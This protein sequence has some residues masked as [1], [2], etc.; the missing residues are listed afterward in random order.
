MSKKIYIENGQTTFDIAIQQFGGV[1]G[2]FSLIRDN[3]DLSSVNDNVFAGHQVNIAD[4]VISASVR[5]Y[6]PNNKVVP[7]S[8]VF[9]PTEQYFCDFNNDF[10]ACQA[11]GLEGGSFNLS[12]NLSFL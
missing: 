11:S 1:E 9:P 7:S 12:F 5:D 6:Y 2:I 4:E 3:D 10:D 8:G